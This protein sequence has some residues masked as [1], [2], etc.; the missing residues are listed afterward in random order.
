MTEFG[1]DGIRKY[2]DNAWDR[3]QHFIILGEGGSGEGTHGN[4]KNVQ[5]F[6]IR[7]SIF[8]SLF[9]GVRIYILGNYFGGVRISNYLLQFVFFGVRIL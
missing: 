5:L 1:A 8:G 7:I 2:T 6:G 4:N 9:S 3:H